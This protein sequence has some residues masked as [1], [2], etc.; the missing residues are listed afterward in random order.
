MHATHKTDGGEDETEFST[1][2]TVEVTYEGSFRGR[3]HTVEAEV[4]EDPYM[5]RDTPEGALDLEAVNE[6]GE[7]Y[8]ARVTEDGT[9]KGLHHATARHDHRKGNVTEVTLVAEAETETALT[10]EFDTV[11]EAVDAAEDLHADMDEVAGKPHVHVKRIDEAATESGF[12]EGDV[13]LRLTTRNMRLTS[14]AMGV[15][16]DHGAEIEHVGESETWLGEEWLLYV[17]VEVPA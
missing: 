17:P 4:I 8:K 14:E 5:H 11:D 15:L 2:D 10:N 12:A 6:D 3:T 7:T 9:L 16:A 1:G 13:T